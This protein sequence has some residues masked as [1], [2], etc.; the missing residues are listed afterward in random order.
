MEDLESDFEIACRFPQRQGT[1]RLEAEGHKGLKREGNTDYGI[2]GRRSYPSCRRQ[3]RSYFGHEEDEAHSTTRRT[4]S[5]HHIQ[6]SQVNKKV[7]ISL[8]LY[9][10]RILIYFYKGPTRQSSPKPPSQDTDLIS[11]R[12]PY[13]AHLLSV[14]LK[15]QSRILQSRSFV[16]LRRERRLL[17]RKSRLLVHGIGVEGNGFLAAGSHLWL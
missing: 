2:T 12:K 3:G 16:V 4:R 7:R 11:D 10:L 14:P 1:N 9:R 8:L 17:R 15:D 6:W 13:P 5:Q